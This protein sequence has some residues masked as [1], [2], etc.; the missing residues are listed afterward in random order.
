MYPDAKAEMDRKNPQVRRFTSDQFK[1]LFPEYYQKWI[2]EVLGEEKNL[3][4]RDLIRG[5]KLA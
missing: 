3:F 1:E 5:K 4:L 2:I